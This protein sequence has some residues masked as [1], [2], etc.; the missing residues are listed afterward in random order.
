MLS[1]ENGDSWDFRVAP[2]TSGEK[3]RFRWSGLENRRLTE[4][5][6]SDY[7]ATQ[8]SPACEDRF[9][10]WANKSSERINAVKRPQ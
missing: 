2:S 5:I 8:F 10:D 3:E 9:S 6:L 1:L 7:Q 4:D